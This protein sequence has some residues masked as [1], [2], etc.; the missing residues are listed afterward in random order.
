MVAGFG[1]VSGIAAIL[2]LVFIA[3]FFA[4]VPVFGPLN[5]IA[6]LVMALATFPVVQ[7]L[8]S[9]RP[10]TWAA[11][12]GLAVWCVLQALMILRLVDYDYQT[13]RSA[14]LVISS[15]GLAVFGGALVTILLTGSPVTGAL[16]LVG[17]GAG[18]GFLVMGVS[19]PIFGTYSPF[20]YA[21]GLA[22]QLGWPVFAIWLARN[23]SVAGTSAP[24]RL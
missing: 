19:I 5:D 2:A 18:A 23:L 6:L 9:G 15:I 3:I 21:G 13:G 11:H 16:R 10:V 22:W 20:T 12:A 1:F 14:G 4:G 17:V 7:L 24:G 8:G